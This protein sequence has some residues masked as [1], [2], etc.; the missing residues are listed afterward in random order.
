MVVIVILLAVII[1]LAVHKG[2]NPSEAAVLKEAPQMCVAGY[3]YPKCWSVSATPREGSTHKAVTHFLSALRQA[4]GAGTT[5]A[6]GVYQMQRCEG[7]QA[8]S[9][10]VCTLWSTGTKSDA[11][12][13]ETQFVDS[14]LFS[15]VAAANS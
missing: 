7:P 8:G 11:H 13:L 12:A 1:S 3:G 14:G 15:D 5:S 4:N 6:L 9:G 2:S 10:V